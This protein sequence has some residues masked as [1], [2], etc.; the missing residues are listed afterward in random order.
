MIETILEYAIDVGAA[1]LAEGLS[2]VN[3]SNRN[4][5]AALSLSL[6]LPLA[7]T[8]RPALAAG[9]LDCAPDHPGRNHAEFPWLV[10]AKVGYLSIIEP[11]EGPEDS[12][13]LVYTPAV[14]V[15]LFF[16]RTLIHSWLE[17]EL[18]VPV[19]FELASDP[20]VFLP[21]DFHF[22]KPF[23]PSPRV[24]PYIGVGPTMDLVL[25]PEVEVFGGL[26]TTVGSYVWLSPRVGLDIE[27]DYNLVFERTELVHEVLVS[28][29][30][31]FRL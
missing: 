3:G 22:K 25:R 16:E 2:L 26:S 19:G 13:A 11:A 29:G 5:C 15:G 18:S 1:A 10:G 7:L 17:I 24:S 4:A 6:A 12:Q 23:H 14:V 8:S 9:P 27:V 21:I 20:K 30:P 28:I 31:A